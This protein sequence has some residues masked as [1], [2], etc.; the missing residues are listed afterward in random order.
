[1][2]DP[3]MFPTNTFFLIDIDFESC[4]V[5]FG[6][7]CFTS[8]TRGDVSIS[9]LVLITIELQKIYYHPHPKDGEGTVFTV[10]CLSTGG[11]PVPGS[12]HG[13]YPSPRFFHCSLVPGLFW[14]VPQSQ[15][16]DTPIPSQRVPLSSLGLGY[17]WLINGIPHS[18]DS[19]NPPTPEAQQQN[20]YLRIRSGRYASCDH[21]GKFSC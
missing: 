7:L 18:W 4:P 16:G 3:G 20:E 15:L 1:M 17:P 5:S 10:V 2:N 19:C 8:I 13:G 9:L 12:F 6:T 21:A 14:G 11:T